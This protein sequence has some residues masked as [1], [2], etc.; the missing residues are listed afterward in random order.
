MFC[1]LACL[2]ITCVPYSC[3]TESPGNGVTDS[4]EPHASAGNLN[5]SCLQEQQVLLIVKSSFQSLLQYL[6]HTH[7]HTQ[8]YFDVTPA[9]II[10]CY[11]LDKLK[12][13]ELSIHTNHPL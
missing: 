2:Y 7:T 9:S 6:K 5:S 3:T 8:S 13:T 11:I 4:C 10:K 1:F 12:T